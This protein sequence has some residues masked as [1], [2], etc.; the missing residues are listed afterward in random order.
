MTVDGNMC[1]QMHQI[2]TQY[3][4]LAIEQDEAIRRLKALLTPDDTYDMLLAML[5]ESTMTATRTR[6][7]DDQYA[8]IIQR[9]ARRIERL[10]CDQA[11]LRLITEQL[12][13]RLAEASG[14]Q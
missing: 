1:D 6:E 3:T 5:M 10:H 8:K 14:D 13:R 2:A 7:M 12:T 9:Q 4:A 11:E